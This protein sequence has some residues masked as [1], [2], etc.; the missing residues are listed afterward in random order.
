MGW[1]APIPTIYSDIL[2]T[3]ASN[4]DLSI[5]WL[6]LSQLPSFPPTSLTPGEDTH[7]PAG[8]SHPGAKPQ[9]PRDHPGR[10]SEFRAECG[11]FKK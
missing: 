8:L 6:A 4:W 10:A 9:C 2:S 1:R 11:D 3:V 5:C 7:L